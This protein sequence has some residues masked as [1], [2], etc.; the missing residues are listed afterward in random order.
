M[1]LTFRAKR[2]TDAIGVLIA[3]QIAFTA[4]HGIDGALILH[5]DEFSY[6]RAKE[7]IPNICKEKAGKGSKTVYL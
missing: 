2:F 7:I 3:A 4:Q 6:R 5:F 1:K